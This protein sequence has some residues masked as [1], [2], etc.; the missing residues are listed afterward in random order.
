MRIIKKIDLRMGTI[1]ENT[2][3]RFYRFIKE[4]FLCIGTMKRESM[5]NDFLKYGLVI[6]L[7]TLPGRICSIID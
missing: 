1:A 6:N 4:N 7:T 3:T 5:T 2:D